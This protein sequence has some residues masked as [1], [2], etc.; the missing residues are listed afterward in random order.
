MQQIHLL[1]ELCPIDVL[2]SWVEKCEIANNSNNEVWWIAED[3]CTTLTI[4]TY[5]LFLY[6]IHSLTSAI[7]AATW[8]LRT[9]GSFGLALSCSKSQ[10]M[11]AIWRLSSTVRS[12]QRILIMCCA[13]K[14]PNKHRVTW[15]KAEHYEYINTS[16]TCS[17]THSSHGSYYN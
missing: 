4:L 9:H 14:Y 17:N 7:R 1:E 3:Y 6:N 15:L 13:I 2:S 5:I 8:L 16:W 12:S 10:A 11:D